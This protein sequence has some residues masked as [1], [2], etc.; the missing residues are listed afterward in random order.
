M[1]Q[2]LNRVNVKHLTDNVFKL[3]D[4]DWMLITAGT[5]DSYN[6]MT[7]SWGTFGILWNLP[8]AVCFIRPQRYTLEFMN[9]SD[10]FTLSFFSENYRDVLSFCGSHSGRKV[11]KAVHTGLTS[12]TTEN[13]GV[14]FAEARIVM[15][16]KKLYVDNLNPK[17]FVKQGFVNEIYPNNDFHHFFIGEIMNCYTSEIVMKEIGVRFEESENDSQP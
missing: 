4:N 17:N 6:T 12:L 14:Y 9:R 5:S 1:V 15:E 2:K 10:F 7:A 8:I 16:C 3:L 11:D 13:G